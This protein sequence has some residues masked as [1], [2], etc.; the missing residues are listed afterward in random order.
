MLVS[1]MTVEPPRSSKSILFK[2]DILLTLT[3]LQL[4]PPLR[5]VWVSS[6]IISFK[7]HISNASWAAYFYLRHINCLQCFITP[8]INAIIVRA[9]IT[10][11]TAVI[12]FYSA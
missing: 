8:I 7:A 1:N 11:T 5:L 12:P 4:L 9:L 2:S 3:D 6:L 10:S